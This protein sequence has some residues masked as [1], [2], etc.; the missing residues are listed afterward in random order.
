M[1]LSVLRFIQQIKC[2]FS[3][4]GGVTVGSKPE[5]EGLLPSGGL[6]Q[7]RFT[8]K[9]MFQKWQKEG[10]HLKQLVFK[11]ANTTAMLSAKFRQ[12]K[13]PQDKQTK[14]GFQEINYKG[15]KD[16]DGEKSIN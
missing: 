11:I 9:R 15:K 12:W 16:R 10:K 7:H 14:N 3:P 2:A 6:T 8:L 1:T 4:G 5:G 13:T